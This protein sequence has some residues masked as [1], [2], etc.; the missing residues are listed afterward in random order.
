M[1]S[2]DWAI[3]WAV[4]RAELVQILVAFVVT[5]IGI[6]VWYIFRRPTKGGDPVGR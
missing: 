2:S 6:G 4:K 1:N 5:L 3:Y